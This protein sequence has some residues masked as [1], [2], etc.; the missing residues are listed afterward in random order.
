MEKWSGAGRLQ[1]EAIVKEKDFVCW[2]SFVIV[3]Y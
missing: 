2:I 1:L 3:H